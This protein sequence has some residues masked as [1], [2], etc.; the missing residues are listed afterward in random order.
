MV[1]DVVIGASRQVLRNFAPAIPIHFVQFQDPF[2]FFSGPLD[3]A[4]VR[5]QMVVPPKRGRSTI[6]SP[7]LD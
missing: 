5:V 6:R 4:N 3:L 7:K 1:L 2:V